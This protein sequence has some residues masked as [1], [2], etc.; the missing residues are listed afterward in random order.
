MIS[1]LQL[2]K[3]HPALIERVHT[4]VKDLDD[5]NVPAKLIVFGSAIKGTV[6]LNSDLDVAYDTTEEY[7]TLVRSTI[8]KGFYKDTYAHIQNM[9]CFYLSNLKPCQLL[10]EIKTTGVCIYNS[11][12][13]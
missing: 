8:V 7:R 6:H 13:V 12:E 5:L 10:F 4:I 1:Y 2:A 9:D 11:M 3:V